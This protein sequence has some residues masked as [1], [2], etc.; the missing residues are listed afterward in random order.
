MSH[1]GIALIDPRAIFEK[2][3]LNKG[4]RVA[5][6][7]CGRTGHFVFPASHVVG[8][9]GVV[10]AVDVMRDVLENVKSRARSEGCDN[11]LAVWSD[12]ECP[13]KT[14][15]MEKSL[16]VCFFTNVLFLVKEKKE[17]IK[18]A[19]RLLKSE[20]RLVIVDWTKKLG[21]LG[22]SPEAMVNIEQIKNL[23][24]E[25]GLEFIENIPAGKYHFCL[26]FKKI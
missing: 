13:G 24:K 12:V 7:G 4:M 16:D 18:E 10:Y 6:M 3:S 2:I 25:E 19:T 8:E 15:I 14:P 26:I 22:P 17:A 9:S 20:G 5:D 1:T 23:A 21:P 11:V